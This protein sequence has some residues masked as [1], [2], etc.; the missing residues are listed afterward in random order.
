VEYSWWARGAA[1][2]PRHYQF[3][4][5]ENAYKGRDK[6]GPGG[7]KGRPALRGMEQFMRIFGVA[8]LAASLFV[9]G[10]L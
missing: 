4:R 6:A 1:G 5:L 7:Y 8:M 3:I 10:F 2:T 9:A